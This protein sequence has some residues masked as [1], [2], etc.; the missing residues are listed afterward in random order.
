[1]ETTYGQGHHAIFP[2]YDFFKG[3]SFKTVVQLTSSFN[4]QSV[5]AVHD[6]KELWIAKVSGEYE[7]LGVMREDRLFMHTIRVKG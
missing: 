3:F 5:L 6:T 2:Q 1:M 7:G 4:L